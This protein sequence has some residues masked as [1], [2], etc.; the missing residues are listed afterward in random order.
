MNPTKENFH[1]T[2]VMERDTISKNR[3]S[4]KNERSRENENDKRE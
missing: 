1:S 3:V 2:R 4:P